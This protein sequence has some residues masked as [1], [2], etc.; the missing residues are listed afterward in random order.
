M[1]G[2]AKDAAVSATAKDGA[3][4]RSAPVAAARRVVVKVGSSSG[5]PTTAAGSTTPRSR[6]GPPKSRR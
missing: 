1:S 5:L 4:L 6:A 3:S 2:A